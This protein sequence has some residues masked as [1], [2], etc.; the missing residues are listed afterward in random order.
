MIM[1]VGHVS[2]INIYDIMITVVIAQLGKTS[3]HNQVLINGQL[4]EL[5]VIGCITNEGNMFINILLPNTVCLLFL[6][7]IFTSIFY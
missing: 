2:N 6:K 3:D 7:F 1:I 4:T 5:S